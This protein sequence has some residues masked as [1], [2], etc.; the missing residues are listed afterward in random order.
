MKIDNL[1][2]IWD[3]EKSILPLG[4]R[5]ATLG[6]EH[7]ANLPCRWDVAKTHGIHAHSESLRYPHR[8]CI[9]HLGCERCHQ[10]K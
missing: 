1:S 5:T 8:E 4:Y 2:Y 6:L 9:L 7:N 3:V 10:N